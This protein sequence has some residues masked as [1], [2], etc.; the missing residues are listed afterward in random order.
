[1]SGVKSTKAW[2]KKHVNDPYVKR[3]Q[4]EGQRSRAVFKLTELLDKYR[5]LHPGMV[6]VELGAAPGSWTELMAKQVGRKGLIV[7][8]DR[9]T[10]YPVENTI[11]LQGDIE[12]DTMLDDLSNALGG[13]KVNWLIS[14]CAPDL[15]GSST[16]DAL[17]TL[18]LAQCVL[19][20]ADNILPLGGGLLLKAFQGAGF[21]EF[22]Q[23]IKQKYDKVRVVKPQ[24]SR[25][26]SREVYILASG[27]K[28]TIP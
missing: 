16:M 28:R 20:L 9:I 27:Y 24:A 5:F 25:A 12:S 23:S 19:D 17:R 11:I 1:M 13:R 15:T 10:M 3:A 26:Q 7:A 8:V 21:T 22:L 6:V 4:Q 2:F 18:H 14:D